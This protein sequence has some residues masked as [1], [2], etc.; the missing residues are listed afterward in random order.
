MWEKLYKYM[1]YLEKLPN[2]STIEMSQELF[3]FCE[4]IGFVTK[5]GYVNFMDK[6]FCLG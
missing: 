2:H 4:A 1:Q 5:D 3:D 6:R